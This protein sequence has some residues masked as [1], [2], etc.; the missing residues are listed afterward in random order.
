MIPGTL[1]HD[2]YL[3]RKAL[4]ERENVGFDLTKSDLCLSF[5]EYLTT[6]G[7]G[8]RVAN[9]Y[10][11]PIQAQK[12]GL[13]AKGEGYP[14]EMMGYYYYPPENKIFIARYADFFDNSLILQE[15]SGSTIDLDEIQRQ[16]AQPSENTREHQPEVENEDVKP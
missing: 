13:R 10:T 7:V 9:S 4:V 3:G 1:Y 16:D 14:K 15:A 5:I 11:D 6:K 2:L 8:L 12:E